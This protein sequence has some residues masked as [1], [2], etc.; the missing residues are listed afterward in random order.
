MNALP[1][2]SHRLLVSTVAERRTVRTPS[3][4]ERK[5]GI[6]DC[7]ANWNAPSAG[8]QKSVSAERAAK[9]RRLLTPGMI[10]AS[11]PFFE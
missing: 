5:P 3:A 6:I 8:A 11:W 1:L 9:A 2:I 7:N 10:S 4:V